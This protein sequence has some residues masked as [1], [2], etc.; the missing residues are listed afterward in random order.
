MRRHTPPCGSTSALLRPTCRRSVASQCTLQIE[1]TDSIFKA[2]CSKRFNN[3]TDPKLLNH[4]V[5]TVKK[6]NL[7]SF[8]MSQAVDTE[9][10]LRA[11][12][13]ES[14]I[15]MN[16]D[17][18]PT[19]DLEYEDKQKSQESQLVYDGL[20]FNLLAQS[21]KSYTQMQN[22]DTRRDLRSTALWDNLMQLN[23]VCFRAE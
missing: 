17:P 18:V 4:N 10:R 6:V 14:K 22:A 23:H 2:K 13:E 3:F 7:F 12:Q 11:V 15:E 8:G 9:K 19:N 1:S 16:M 20:R 21:S 5:H